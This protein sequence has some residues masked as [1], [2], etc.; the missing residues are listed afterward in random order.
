MI[1]RK[2]LQ[3]K[4]AGS[5][6]ALPL[7][8]VY[9]LLVW[10]AAGLVHDRR[11]WMPFGCMTLTTYL[12]V[13]LNNV[14]ALIRTYSRMVSC[15]FL[16][17]MVMSATTYA[18]MQ[19]NMVQLC[20]VVF[21]MT[22]FQ[23]YQ[24]KTAA[25]WVF[26]AFFCLGMAS[27]PFAQI[28]FF[29]PFVWLLMRTTIMTL[30]WRT[31]FAS[32]LGLVTPYWFLAA[33]S[34]L[35]GQPMLVVDMLTRVADIQPLAALQS[36]DQHMAVTVVFVFVLGLTGTV[37][38]LRNSYLDRIRIRMFFYTFIVVHFLTVVFIVMQPLHTGVLLKVM[39]I[40]ASVLIAHFIT[41]TKT[42]VTNVAFII[43]LTTVLLLT[44]YNLWIPS[45][46]F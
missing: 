11:M 19:A 24:D 20:M 26:Y 23:A 34:L 22:L 46:R 40:P 32:I 9:A 27:M 13:E 39:I 31:F 35:V 12:M 1:A 29:V 15:S 43:I 2:K 6:Y 28:L 41:L 30:S 44:I 36:V 8:A 21:F 5:K 37:H 4:I 45:L 7:T 16:M 10:M 17:L 3:N 25:G 18:D 14:N 38:F 42:H 33:Y